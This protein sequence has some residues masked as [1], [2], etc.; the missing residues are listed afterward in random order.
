MRINKY[1][2]QCGIGSRRQ[3]DNYIKEGLVKVNGTVVRDFSLSV[4]KNDYVQYN[5]KLIDE[6]PTVTYML[7][8]PRGYICSKN[9]KYKRK[10]IYE[11]LPDKNLF[12]IGRLDYDTTGLILLTN[13]GDLCYRLSHPKFEIKKKYFVITNDKLNNN[14]IN[15]INQKGLIVEDNIKLKAKIKFL[16][17]EKTT[18]FWDVVLTEGKNREIKKIFNYFDIRVLNLHRYD[19]G[20]LL[21]KNL[22]EGKYK[23]INKRELK[24]LDNAN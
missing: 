12:S 14:Q 10:M 13:D 7:N 19:F 22:K 17:K 24:I 1:L 18:Y 16:S 21:L 20:G 8:K 5:N 3:C 4:Q 9:D 23:R 2:A 15:Q 11:L 6:K